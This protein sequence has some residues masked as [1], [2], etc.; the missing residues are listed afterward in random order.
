MALLIA[1]IVTIVGMAFVLSLPNKYT[2]QAV[3]HVDT[4]SV[5]TPLLKG[6]SVESENDA[7][8]NIMTRVLLSRKNLEDVIRQTDMDLKANTPEALDEMIRQL[9]RSVELKLAGKR[10][11]GIYELSYTGQSPELVYK[12]VSKLLNTLIENTLE[13]SRTDTASAQQFIN[14][15]I[16]EYEVRLTSAE[17]KLAAFK[18]ANVGFMPDKTG[19]YYNRLQNEE[20]LLYS[21]K[22]ELKL[23]KR[24]YSTMLKQLE[25]ELPLLDSSYGAPKV[26]K[27]RKYQEQLDDLLT[28][29]QEQH[30]DVKSLKATIADLIASDS[31]GKDSYI[32]VGSGEAVAFNPVYQELKANINKTTIDVEALTI[33][34]GEQKN[35]V[36]AL[37]QAVDIIPGVEAELAKLNRDYEITRERY[38]SFVKR[39]EAARLAQ[40]V[41]QSGNSIKFRI[42][43]PPRV[44]KEPSGPRRLLFLLGVFIFSIAAG[45]GWGV[46]N[47][48]IKPTFIDS[49]QLREKLGLPILGSVGYNFS[50]EGKKLRQ[51]QL[52]SYIATL[53]LLVVIYGAAMIFNEPG[54]QLVNALI[55]S[56]SL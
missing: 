53:L 24:K 26:L 56:R 9:S 38:L 19:G 21:I 51:L 2:A 20:R 34:L 44:P 27:L 43:E 50:S 39:R 4:T 54:S 12:V 31:G 15:Q 14:R 48:L 37:K 13:S 45:L 23:V 30:P 1:F 3:V 22:A 11:A 33:T 5:M 6:L 35:K 52:T 10:N 16:E 32:N 41:G 29:Y 7:G 17:Q 40:A 46:F 49:S 55:E 8:L 47:Y 18:R 36:Q 42:I 25:G 28:Q